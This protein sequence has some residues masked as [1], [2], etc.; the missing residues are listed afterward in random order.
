MLLTLRQ[1]AFVGLTLGITP[2]FVL[3]Q[4][5]RNPGKAAGRHPE[6]QAERQAQKHEQQQAARPFAPGGVGRAQVP[7]RWIERLQEMPPDQ[8]QRF[9]QNNQHF[10]NL[11]PERQA[12]IRQNL[13]RWNRLTPAQQQELRERRERLERLSPEDRHRLNEEIL[14]RWQQLPADRR[15]AI[16]RRLNALSPLNEKDREAKLKDEQFLNGLNPED[17]DLLRNLATLR[18]GP[19]PDHPEPPNL[20]EP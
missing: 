20:D 18:L 11:P 14:P 13:E 1:L 5:P 17:R 12:Q 7:P 2:T 19:P 3:S 4:N 16:R 15:Q 6:R 10:R 8:Q 9:M